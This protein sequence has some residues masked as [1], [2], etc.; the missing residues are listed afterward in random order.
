[1]LAPLFI[2]YSGRPSR[3]ALNR[4]LE[5]ISSL[6]MAVCMILPKKTATPT[7]VRDTINKPFNLYPNKIYLAPGPDENLYL[8]KLSLCPKKK[9]NIP[10]PPH[11]TCGLLRRY[12]KN[13]QAP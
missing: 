2:P 8:S 9:L 11:L 3:E 5:K 6:V 4:G 12:L 10:H 1:M 13:E 7:I